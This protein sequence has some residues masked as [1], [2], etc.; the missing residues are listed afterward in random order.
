MFS[1]VSD[2]IQDPEETWSIGTE[3]QGLSEIKVVGWANIDKAPELVEIHTNHMAERR[4]ILDE[5]LT[6]IVEIDK[7]LKELAGDSQ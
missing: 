5:K 2:V 1:K 3:L 6:R 7:K 4:K